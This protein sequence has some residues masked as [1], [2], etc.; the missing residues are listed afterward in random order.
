MKRNVF[1]KGILISVVI[2][3]F[4][5]AL[6]GCVPTTP[7]SLTGIVN[8]VLTGTW[9]YNLNMDYSEKFSG[10]SSGTYTLYNVP[11]G[12]HYFEA[13]NILGSSWG[14]FAVTKYIGVGT[15]NIYLYPLGESI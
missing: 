2:V 5:L 10:V 14:Y 9:T 7:P 1:I 11:I 3:L 6:V 4:T 12:D 15:N 13:I 8:I